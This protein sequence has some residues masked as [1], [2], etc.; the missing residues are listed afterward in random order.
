MQ[1][2]GTRGAY[3]FC[4]NF[5][6]DS[7]VTTHTWNTCV[8]PDICCALRNSPLHYTAIFLD[9]VIV[10]TEEDITKSEADL[11]SP[12]KLVQVLAGAAAVVG[13]FNLTTLATLLEW[14]QKQVSQEL[15]AKPGYARLKKFWQHTQLLQGQKQR[16]S[17]TE[18]WFFQR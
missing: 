14:K 9:T 3:N 4:A 5:Q 13:V 8:K 16:I 15:R 10:K 18:A 11:V 12:Y 2:H 1:V 6:H 7:C 17:E